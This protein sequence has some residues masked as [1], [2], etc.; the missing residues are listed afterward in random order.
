MLGVAMRIAQRMGLHNESTH[1]EYPVFESEMRRRLWWS[2]VLF[3]TRMCEMSVY[4]T[5]ILLPTWDCR[6]PLNINDFDLQPE[7]KDMP[8]SHEKPTEA[9]FAV[10]RSEMGDIVRHSAFHLDFVS[11]ALKAITRNPQR[12]Q[13]SESGDLVAVQKIIED[14]YLK[15]CNPENPLHFFTIWL[16]RG[17]LAKSRLYEHYSRF[18]GS[19]VQPT[20]AQRDAAIPHAQDMLECDTKL[21]ASPIIKGYKWFLDMYFPFPAYNH[22]LQDLK[23]RPVS[24]HAQRSWELMSDNYEA[25]SML[26]VEDD[27]PFLKIFIKML[28]QA[29]EACEAGLKQSGA[30]LDLPRI[31]SSIGQKVAQEKQGS[32]DIGKGDSNDVFSMDID[33]SMSMPLDSHSY[34]RLQG[35]GRAQAFPGSGMRPYYNAPRQATANVN[36]NDLNLDSMNWNLLHGFGW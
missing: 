7:M 1:A 36:L 23:R 11:P 13:V 6:I 31:V 29:W 15:F 12:S 35:M 5:S 2:L 17:Q 19:S 24:N 9:L 3:D 30:P 22:L 10:V 25:R 8:V 18:P 14:K 20:D 4:T 26:P 28:L 16:M 33:F 32:Q 27:N 21:S 34:N